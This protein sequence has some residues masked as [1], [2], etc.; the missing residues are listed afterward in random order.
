[1]SPKR[2]GAIILM[3]SEEFFDKAEMLEMLYWWICD[4]VFLGFLGKSFGKLSGNPLFGAIIVV[5]VITIR[6]TVIRS[7]IIMARLIIDELSARMFVSTFATPLMP[8]EWLIASMIISFLQALLR[9]CLGYTLIFLLFG[10]NVFNIGWSL[11]IALPFFI[12]SGLVFGFLTSAIIYV[13][14]KM[15]YPLLKTFS[16]A[17]MA[18]CGAFAPVNVL[19]YALQY[20]SWCVPATYLLTG[21]REH[22]L[23]GISLWPFLLKN[24]ALNVLWASVTLPLLYFAFRYAKQRGLAHLENG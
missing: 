2:I 16:Y 6:V 4:M 15:G 14:G 23:T 24:L 12:L 21:L 13:V 10:I 22:I 20:I 18:L 5:S 1:M 7:S 8:T 11:F 17:F 19:P 3:H 9:L